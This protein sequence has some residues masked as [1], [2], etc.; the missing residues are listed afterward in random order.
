MTGARMPLF[1]NVKTLH[2]YVP[3]PGYTNSDVSMKEINMGSTIDESTT[4][5]YYVVVLSITEYQLYRIVR[6]AYVGKLD[7]NAQRRARGMCA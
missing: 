2:E 3:F 5:Y 6:R 4:S 1:E 7:G